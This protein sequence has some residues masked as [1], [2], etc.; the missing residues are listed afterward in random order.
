M[1]GDITV[2]E[3]VGTGGTKEVMV[4]SESG[5]FKEMIKYGYNKML[6]LGPKPK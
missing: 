2:V 6:H 3:Y 5:K 1:I 4:N